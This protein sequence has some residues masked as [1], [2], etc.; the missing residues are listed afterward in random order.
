MDNKTFQELLKKGELGLI[1]MDGGADLTASQMKQVK[2]LAKE[3]SDAKINQ[4]AIE[5]AGTPGYREFMTMPLMAKLL[6]DKKPKENVDQSNISQETQSDNVK[7]QKPPKAEV[8]RESKYTKIPAGEVRPLKT[9]DSVS[10]VMAKMTNFMFKQ[11]IKDTKRLNIEKKHN[12]KLI[13]LKEKRIAELISLFGG[14]YKAKVIREE[15]SSF[16]SKLLSMIIIGTGLFLLS[17]KAIA[18]VDLKPLFP[19]IPSFANILRKLVGLPEVSEK[20][21][22]ENTIKSTTTID[23]T[24][25]K[26]LIGRESGNDYDK[27]VITSGK[28]VNL[29]KPITE[30]TISEVYDLQDLMLKNGYPSSALGRYQIIKSTLQD[31]VKK[32]NIDPKTTLYD[33]DTQDRLLNRLLLDAGL[34]D[35]KSGKLSKEEFQNKLAGIWAAIPLATDKFISDKFGDRNLKAGQS[36]YSG[37][38]KNAAYIPQAAINKVLEDVK[39]PPMPEPVQESS[40]K[41]EIPTKLNNTP[42]KQ[43]NVSMINN[44]N[45]VFNGGTNYNITETTLTNYPVIVDKQYFTYG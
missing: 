6:G 42:Q 5:L 26:S 4:M 32:E 11:Y 30:M 35:F 10:D 14:N 23:T 28:Q 41:M 22:D 29:N 40:V 21:T 1:L 37:V 19:E 15:K 16:M 25:F 9:G 2:S 33:S 31:L 27:L 36:Y 20:E 17:K 34:E 3:L 12:N 13:N 45:N 24:D 44:S 18:S 43:S 38:G 8:K 39:T 7:E